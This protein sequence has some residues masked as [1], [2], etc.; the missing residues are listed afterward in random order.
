LGTSLFKYVDKA[1]WVKLE[2]PYVRLVGV[3][4]AGAEG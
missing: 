4:V 2:K 1:A 3:L